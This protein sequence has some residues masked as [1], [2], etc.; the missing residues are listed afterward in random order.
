MRRL[1]MA[2]EMTGT[3]SGGLKTEIRH[4]PSGAMQ[5]TAAP[6]D[7]KGD[8]S[9]F[10][11]SDLVAGALGACAVTTMAIAADREGIPFESAHFVVEK[12]MESNPRRIA[13]L[14]LRVQMPAGLTQD[15]RTYLEKV[16]RTCPV[17]RSLL[18]EIE[19]EFIFDYGDESTE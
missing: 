15:Q 19:R 6:V 10:A 1:I 8:G 14:A 9:S 11:P 2:V 13:R 18:A 12:H 5:H 17:E 16:A 7:N 4:G 3:Y